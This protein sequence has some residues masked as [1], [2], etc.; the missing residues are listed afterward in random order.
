[1]QVQNKEETTYLSNRDKEAT[2]IALAIA[3]KEIQILPSASA[4]A[5]TELQ[6][7]P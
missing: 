7:F 5:S 2:P 1:M 4:P 3:S 6:K